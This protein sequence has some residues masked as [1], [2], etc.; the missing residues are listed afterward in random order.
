MSEGKEP[1]RKAV[2]DLLALPGLSLHW[3]ASKVVAAAS[4]DIGYVYGTYENT[5]NGPKGKPISEHGKYVE[6]WK[7]QADGSWKC[8]VDTWNSDSPAAPSK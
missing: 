4:G 3:Q 7:K 1:I 5:M 6:V 8:A 2:G